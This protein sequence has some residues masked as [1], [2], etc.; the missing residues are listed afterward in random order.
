MTLKV[1]SFVPYD[2]KQVLK[3]LRLSLGDHRGVACTPKAT[4]I[5][6]RGSQPLITAQQ[7]AEILLNWSH[8]RVPRALGNIGSPSARGVIRFA[9][10]AAE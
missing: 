3:V 6:G 9:V 5:A 7:S 8:D 4:L 2:P 1:R 10:R